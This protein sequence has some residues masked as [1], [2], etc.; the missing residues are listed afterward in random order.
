M[1]YKV[2]V[3]NIIFCASCLY[4][5]EDQ[6]IPLPKKTDVNIKKNG[7]KDLEKLGEAAAYGLQ[8]VLAIVQKY[9]LMLTTE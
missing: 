5:Q 3:L 9:Y 8:E 4:A 6:S 1:N 2:V 7:S